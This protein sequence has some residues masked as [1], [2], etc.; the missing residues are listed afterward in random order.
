MLRATAAT[1]VAGMPPVP[2]TGSAM[3]QLAASGTAAVP[4]PERVSSRRAGVIGWNRVAVAA[5]SPVRG[6]TTRPSQAFG[7]VNQ[8]ERRPRA[9]WNWTPVTVTVVAV[10]TISI[11]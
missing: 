2:T 6:G 5:G 11:E 9:A 1:P 3:A 4:V 7:T 10:P 8:S